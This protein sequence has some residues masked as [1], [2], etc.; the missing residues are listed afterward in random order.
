MKKQ[1]V[2]LLMMAGLW[3]NSVAV[4]H[5]LTDEPDMLDY[6]NYPIFQTNAVTPNIHIVLDNSGSMNFNAYGTWPGDND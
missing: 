4:A 6:T 5:A 1:L 3:M 2:Y